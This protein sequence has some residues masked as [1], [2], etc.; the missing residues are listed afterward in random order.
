[1]AYENLENRDTEY[2]V[3][4]NWIKQKSY[5]WLGR[6]FINY[7]SKKDSNL[8]S[9]YWINNNWKYVANIDWEE[10]SDYIYENIALMHFSREWDN[11][12]TL[13]SRDWSNY[14][15]NCVLDWY[16]NKVKSNYK[17]S[18]KEITLI[19]KLW[20]KI[21]NMSY[22]KRNKYNNLLKQYLTKFEEWTK[23]YEIVRQLLIIIDVNWVFKF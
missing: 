9:Y 4:K 15:L 3:I 22:Y 18:S 21:N 19:E 23:K 11:L 6:Q 10:I 8:I 14:L 16:S 17:L 13:A 20:E 2:F 1:M 7:S 5:S 12:Y